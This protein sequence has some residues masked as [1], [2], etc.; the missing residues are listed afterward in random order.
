MKEKGRQ[1]KK[2][3]WVSGCAIL[4][5]LLVAGVNLWRLTKQKPVTVEK[6]QKIPVQVCTV[7]AGDLDRF[8][9]VTGDLRPLQAVEVYPKVGGKVIKS[10]LVEKGDRVKKGQLVACLEKDRIQAQ[11]NR[12]RAEVKVTRANLEMLKKDFRRIANLQEKK[13]ASKQKLDHIQAELEVASARIE[14]AKAAL[15]E[16][17]VLYQDHDI[18]ATMSG[19]IAARYMDPGSFSKIGS[20]IL[21]IS[22]EKTLK[23]V[24]T[25]PEMDFPQVREGMDV[26]FRVDAYP[27][28]TFIGKVALVYPTLDPETR[29]A[30]V[31]IRVPNQDLLLRSGMFAHVR[32][33]FG[34]N[35]AIIIPR[36]ALNKMPG[37]G[38][39]YVYVVRNSTAHL[40]NIK[41]GGRQGNLAE[42]LSGLN[43][44]DQVV[45]KG[46][47]RLKDGSSVRV[48]EEGKP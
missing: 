12:A 16:L 27:K 36:D 35:K 22:N 23:V 19:I 44:E 26:K 38:C 39:Y 8:L 41:I 28:N 30:K 13:A 24:T 32:L 33:Y 45:V 21:R 46:Q 7:E 10:I 9:E 37:T 1:D 15:K 29:T 40:R 2:I 20:P 43:P 6:A 18:Y 3:M 17:E 48:I 34:K 11:V 4:I 31:E 42:V 14:Q 5:F 25:V 47:M